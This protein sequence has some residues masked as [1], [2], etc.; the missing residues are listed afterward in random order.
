MLAPYTGECFRSHGDFHKMTMETAVL[1]SLFHSV[2]Q[3][4]GSRSVGTGKFL[5]LQDPDPLVFRP[6]GS[7]SVIICSDQFYQLVIHF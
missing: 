7:G 3:C 6:P 5:S 2:Q 4:Y 1:I